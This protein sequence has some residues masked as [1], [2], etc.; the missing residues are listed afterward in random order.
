MNVLVVAAA[1]VCW[2]IGSFAQGIRSTPITLTDKITSLDGV[3]IYDPT[4]GVG[5]SCDL[6]DQNDRIIR[7][8]V[9]PQGVNVESGRLTKQLPLDGSSVTVRDSTVATAAL[10]QAIAR[11]ARP[12]RAHVRAHPSKTHRESRARG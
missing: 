5:G 8:G 4:K 1:L 11:A 2:P 6:S 9:T 10:E 3:W 12:F 7:I